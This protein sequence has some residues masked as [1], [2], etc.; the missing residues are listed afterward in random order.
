TVHYQ[1]RWTR[2][3]IPSHCSIAEGI[4]HYD[5]KDIKDSLEKTVCCGSSNKSRNSAEV[6]LFV[7]SSGGDGCGPGNNFPGI[8]DPSGRSGMKRLEDSYQI[9]CKDARKRLCS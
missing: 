9:D 3:T 6:E 1:Q 4:K 2:N 7:K 5:V 8:F